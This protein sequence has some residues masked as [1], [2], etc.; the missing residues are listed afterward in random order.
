M[1]TAQAER[2]RQALADAR[3]DLIQAKSL[4]K[5]RDD[6]VTKVTSGLTTARLKDRRVAIVRM[7]NAEDSLVD[8]VSKEL[9]AAGAQITTNVSLDSELFSPEQRP[10]VDPLVNQLVTADVTFGQDSTTY[11]RAGQILARGI[12][13]K[14]EGQSVDDDATKVISGLTG[15]KLM[16]VK[17]TPKDRATLVVVVAGKPPTPAPDDNTY[18]DAV[19]LTEGLDTGSGGVVLAGT[20]ETAQNGGLLKAMRADSTLPRTSPRSTSRTC[21]ADA[22]PWCSRWSSRPR[23]RPPVRRRGRQG[24]CR[25]GRGTGRRALTAMGLGRLGVAVISAG[26]T[27]LLERAADRL[28]KEQQEPFARTNF[29]GEPVT[30]LEGPVTVAAAL[31]G[32]LADTDAPGR[33]R[34]AAAVAG[35]VSGAVGAYD[36]L[37]GT[38]QAKLPRSSERPAPGRGDQRRSEDRGRRCCRAGSTALLPRRSSGLDRVVDVIA[39]GALIAGTANVV[40]LLDLR[41]GRAAKAVIALSVPVVPFRGPGA[42]VAGATAAAAPSDLAGRSML[43]DCGAN[44]LG[45]MAGTALAAALPRPLRWLALAGVVGLNLAS[46]KVSFTEVIKNNPTLRAVD[47]WAGH[48]DDHRPAARRGRGAGGG[49][50]G[51]GPG[52][53]VRALAGVLQDGRCELP[54]GRV[55]DREPGCRTC[56][57]R[58]RSAGRSRGR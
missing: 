53:R 1:V 35:A 14:E 57:S 36:D 44:G 7:P 56:C 4:D 55:H 3:E 40:N 48:H 26:A 38:A 51:G 11:Q 29:R 2:D 27:A 15:S 42:A 10:M 54:R 50:H 52:V 16:G 37:L 43:G 46:E 19:D 45:A 23:A 18:A 47:E 34:A 9:E 28:P 41:P 20:P 49:D 25:A 31:V 33:V 6:Y 12:A 30:L 24:R 17:P 22:R 13:A 58:W 32:V 21:R 5:Y 39:D 8:N